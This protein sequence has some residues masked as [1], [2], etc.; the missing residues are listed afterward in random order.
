MARE[1]PAVYFVMGICGS[2]KSTVAKALAEALG[3]EML[4]SDDFHPA[5]NVE[6]LSAG[7]ALTDEDRAGWLEA[8]N[9][10]VR[11]RQDRGVSAVLA[12][13]ALK[14]TYRDTLQRGLDT[15]RWI[16]LRGERSVILQRMEERKD[17]FMPPSLVDSQLET[18][19]EP[20]SALVLDIR[21]SVAEIVERV[22][23]DL[24]RTQA[25]RP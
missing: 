7:I 9:R 24:G 4:D 13:S 21:Q 10:E 1:S 22:L 11:A 15:F 20:T 19:E 18:L 3:I 23:A 8:L 6:K 12:C 16:Y 2:G 14:Q 25:S 5:S 17:H